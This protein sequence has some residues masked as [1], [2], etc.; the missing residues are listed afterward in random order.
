MKK[1]KKCYL[2]KLKC[3]KVWGQ[4]ICSWEIIEYF[5]NVYDLKEVSWSVLEWFERV[6]LWKHK[7]YLFKLWLYTFKCNEET[8]KR[9]Y[10]NL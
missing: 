5:G 2:G 8:E 6:F 1:M 9:R 3:N 10:E 4:K 7:R